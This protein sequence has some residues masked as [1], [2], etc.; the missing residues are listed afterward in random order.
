MRKCRG[1]KKST[2]ELER[3]RGERANGDRET[4][5]TCEENAALEIGDCEE[6]AGEGAEETA[7]HEGESES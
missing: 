2:A 6:E 4:R 3:G 7:I 1:K 5:D